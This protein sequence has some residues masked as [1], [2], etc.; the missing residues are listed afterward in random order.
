MKNK[1]KKITVQV[2]KADIAAGCR[3][4]TMGCPVARAMS[5]R[6]G[7]EVSVN[8]MQWRVDRDDKYHNCPKEV[9]RFVGAFD[10]WGSDN[11]KPF[12]FKITRPYGV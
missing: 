6:L 7:V 9:V 2:T 10:R 1:F 4:D 12:K 11:V 3:Y 8:G 5:R